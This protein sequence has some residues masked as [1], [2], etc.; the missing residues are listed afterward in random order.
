MDVMLASQKHLVYSGIYRLCHWLSAF[1]LALAVLKLGLRPKLLGRIGLLLLHPYWSHGAV[2]YSTIRKSK[3]VASHLD[4]L[5]DI[6]VLYLRSSSKALQSAISRKCSAKSTQVLPIELS[7]TSYL[8]PRV[9]KYNLLWGGC[10]NSRIS[11][12]RKLVLVCYRDGVCGGDGNAAVSAS[13]RAEWMAMLLTKALMQRVVIVRY[14]G[15]GE[16]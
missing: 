16:E 12:L 4:S 13:I 7:P 15:D 5:C 14:S 8:E 11:S 1:P 10:S 2:I 6:E 9:D 3:P